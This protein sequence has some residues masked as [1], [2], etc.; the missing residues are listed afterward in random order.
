MTIL[1][2]MPDEFIDW[3][4]ECPVQW[5]LDNQTDESLT[6]TFMKPDEEEV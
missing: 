1:I 6:Y 2:G 5:F 3:L 4:E